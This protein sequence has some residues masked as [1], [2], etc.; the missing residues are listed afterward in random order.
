MKI[1]HQVC[2]CSTKNPMKLIWY[3]KKVGGSKK[4]RVSYGPARPTEQKGTRNESIVYVSQV[5]K[6]EGFSET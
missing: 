3:V 1:G 5:P 4:Q 6:E 2:Q